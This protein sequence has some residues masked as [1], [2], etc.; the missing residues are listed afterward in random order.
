MNTQGE[1]GLDLQEGGWKNSAVANTRD[2]DT[3]ESLIVTRAAPNS[4][5]C[6]HH[7]L[8]NYPEWQMFSSIGAFL[9]SLGVF[10]HLTEVGS[11]GYN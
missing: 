9:N 7:C 11:F 5:I 1:Q 4:L 6:W 10:L 8:Q 2:G 3:V